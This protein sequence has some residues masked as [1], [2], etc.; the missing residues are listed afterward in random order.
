MLRMAIEEQHIRNLYKRRAKNDEN[1][2]TLAQT[3]ES[4][5][6][7]AFKGEHKFIFE[8]LQNADD[9]NHN[10]EKIEASLILKKVISN[11]RQYLIF[12]HSGK[13]FSEQDVER[14]C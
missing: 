8:L 3:L 4:N 2:S 13:H 11:D 12:S 9:A 14:I 1:S 6:F 10:E 7:T 5:I